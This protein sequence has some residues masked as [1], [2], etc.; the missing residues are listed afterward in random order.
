LSLKNIVGG[1][2]LGLAIIAGSA[3]AD[4]KPADKPAEKAP[5]KTAPADKKVALVDINTATQEQLE[6]V[7]GIGKENCHHIIYGRPYTSTDELVARSILTKATYDKVK[8]RLT[9]A[10]ADTKPAPKAMP[11]EMAL[12]DINT[13]S[14]EQLEAVP[15]IGKENCHHIIYGRPYKT[16]DELV[17]RSILTKESY[18]KAKDRLTVAKAEAKPAPKTAPKK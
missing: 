15:G 6:A 5:A 3:L 10:Q 12:V 18:D 2:F 7:P 1:L 17:A 8:D 4:T 11:A 16:T 14:Q 9:V 13:A